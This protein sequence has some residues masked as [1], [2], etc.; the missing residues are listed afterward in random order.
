MTEGT[1][2]YLHRIRHAVVCIVTDLSEKIFTQLE[3]KKIRTQLLHLRNSKSS[4]L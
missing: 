4:F 1:D 2:A 3:G